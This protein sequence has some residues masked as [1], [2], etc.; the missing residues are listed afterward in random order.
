M[1]RAMGVRTRVPD[2]AT[3]AKRQIADAAARA[4]SD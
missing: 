3:N 4:A 1:L 2:I